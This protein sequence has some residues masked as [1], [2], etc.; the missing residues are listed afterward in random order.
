[1]CSAVP[2]PEPAI[3]RSWLAGLAVAA[4]LAAAPAWAAPTACPDSYLGG[5]AP[6]YA[7]L[8]QAEARELCFRAFAVLHSGATRTPLWS[9]EHLTASSVA[10]AAGVS[11]SNRFHA[12]PGLPRSERSELADYRRSGYDRGHMA[13][14]GDMPDAASQR[15]SFSLA[16]M[17]PQNHRLNTGTWEKIEEAA[18]AVASTDGEAWVVTGPLFVGSEVGTIGTRQ[19]V[20]IPTQVWK[21]V[22]DP[23]RHGAAVY[24]ADN[25]EDANCRILSVA[26]FAAQS[27]I[28]PFPA[29]PAGT[30]VLPLREPRTC[31]QE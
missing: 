31:R 22:Y 23:A 15:E 4:S 6:A 9:A 12:E 24:L 8:A 5:Q 19:V 13:P 17:V 26:A 7:K 16:N 20:A 10:A 14:S 27:G 18:R 1:M 3:H 28:Q 30:G 11:R 25:A 29:L 2:A 21:A